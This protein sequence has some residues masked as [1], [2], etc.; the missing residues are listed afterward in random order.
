MVTT[1]SRGDV[2]WCLLVLIVIVSVSVYV[3]RAQEPPKVT[4]DS[5]YCTTTSFTQ[6]LCFQYRSIV[7]LA[8]HEGY[9]S[10]VSGQNFNL[11]QVDWQRLAATDLIPSTITQP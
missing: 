6:P 2:L 8:P 5:W 9:V 4:T 7:M 11:N 10:L 3:V 1:M